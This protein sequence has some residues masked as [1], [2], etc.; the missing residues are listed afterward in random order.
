MMQVKGAMHRAGRLVVQRIVAGWHHASCA[1]GCL[2]GF[3]AAQHAALSSETAFGILQLMQEHNHSCEGQVLSTAGS[4][5]RVSLPGSVAV[6]QAVDVDGILG[7]VLQYD[8]KGAVVALVVR[9]EPRMGAAVLPRGQLSLRC[10]PCH[11]RSGEVAFCPVTDLLDTQGTTATAFQLPTMPPPPQRRPVTRRLPSNL[12]TLEALL[13]LGE[14]HRVG[15]VG[16]VG[17]GKSTAARILTCSQSW[18]TAI[19]Y[20]AYK[21]LPQL[22][23]TLLG[24]VANVG[25]ALTVVYSDPRSDPWGAQYLLPFAASQVASQ[26]CLAHKHVLL[27][28]DDLTTFAGL[29]AELPAPPLSA[30]H[31]LAAMLD[32]AGN[33]SRHGRE[34]AFSVVAVLD[35]EPEDE[36]P[37]VLRDLW[38]SIEPALDVCVSFSAKVAMEGVLPAIDVDRLL[39]SGFAPP[40]QS[41]FFKQLRADLLV[42][43]RKSRDLHEKINVGKQLGLHVEMEDQQEMLSAR[44]ARAM[45]AHSG[46]RTQQE[47]AVLLVAA[48]VYHFP[49]RRQPTQ[50]EIGRFQDAVIDTVRTKYPALWE[51]LGV[52][53]AL[54]KAEATTAIRD[55]GEVLLAHRFSF[56]ITRPD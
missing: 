30:P 51:I 20:A 48:L 41:P 9:G 42:A 1:P 17:T 35:L 14:G 38:R 36:L 53:D 49:R 32:A 11:S 46:P 19:V 33:T 31:V 39:A 40:H 45:L 27:V 8:R 12:A 7:V 54:S 5:V 52:T 10:D 13:P 37:P 55:L 3:H 6:G 2:R 26:L 34:Q 44:V 50:F 28:L 29:A 16:P 18:D 22:E 56:Q 15:F 21:P 23:A 25:A 24:S 4:L 47:L 43:F